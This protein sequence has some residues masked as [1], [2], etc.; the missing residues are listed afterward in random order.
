MFVRTRKIRLSDT[1]ATGALYFTN[2]LKFAA[3]LFEAFLEEIDI[4][5]ST[6]IYEGDILFPIVD[7]KSQYLDK[8][9]V[10]DEITLTLSCIE[11]GHSSFVIE[12]IIEKDQ[13]LVGKTQI[14]HVSVSKTTNKSVPIPKE[15][16]ENAR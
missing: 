5:L 1:D 15:F 16:M 2:Q 4:P 11:R 3:E 8:L 9:K 12:T 13:R 10:G 6:Q 7:A 14:T